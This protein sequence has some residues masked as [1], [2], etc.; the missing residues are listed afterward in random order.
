M[1][2][3]Q[4]VVVPLPPPWWARMLAAV[5]WLYA[6]AYL[7][8]EPLRYTFWIIPLALI[9]AAVTR[10]FRTWLVGQ[11]LQ[12]VA[13]GLLYYVV[14]AVIMTNGLLHGISAAVYRRFLTSIIPWSLL[15]RDTLNFQLHSLTG[16]QK[17]SYLSI[18]LLVVVCL[19]ASLAGAI[20]ALTKGPRRKLDVKSTDKM[21]ESV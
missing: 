9:W 7:V 3:S 10:R 16:L 14:L 13:L 19:L 17:Q 1:K 20:I 11:V 12:A 4:A 21:E 8:I 15:S 18:L 5:T 6:G 2:Q